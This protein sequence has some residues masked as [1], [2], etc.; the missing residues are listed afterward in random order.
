MVAATKQYSQQDND[1]ARAFLLATAI[2][3]MK[4]LPPVSVAL[5]STAQ[6]PL[7]RMG[8]MTGVLLDVSIPINVTAAAT[9]SQFGPWNVFSQVKY[10]DFAGVD[11]INTNGYSLWAVET[12]KNREAGGSAIPFTGIAGIGNIDTD[13]LSQ[14]V[15]TGAQTI[16]FQLYV[17]CAYDPT[18]DLRGAVLAQTV[19]G[20]HYI[21]LATVAALVGTDAWTAPYTAGTAATT[22]NITITATQFYLQPQTNAP[23]ALPYFDLS[24]IYAIEG[25]YSDTSNIVAGQSKFLNW[26]NNRSIFSALHVFD[27]GG[28]GT[29]NGADLS[30]IILLANANT[31]L[32]ELSPQVL[33]GMM[34]KLVGADVASG[35][36]YMGARRQPVTTQLF[37]N[38]QTQFNIAS[39]AGAGPV[40]IL[41]QYESMYPS[42]APLPGIQTN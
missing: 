30:K 9:A 2:P 25:N 18:S 16:R 22:G 15:G 36:Y 40:A 7:Q 23:A 14:P 4:Q 29:L 1:N 5:G 33:R 32:R 19:V 26:P 38:V 27:N 41:S 8:I 11:R 12:F 21:T 28:A 34:R 10:T 3:M 13:I 17:P 37:G 35:V 39:V 42:G 6:I 31:N 24:T 20:E